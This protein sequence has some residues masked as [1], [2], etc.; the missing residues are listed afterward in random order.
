MG[1]E[2]SSRVSREAVGILISD[3]NINLTVA[4]KDLI[5]HLI[6]FVVSLNF[7]FSLLGM[8]S[9]VSYMLGKYLVLYFSHLVSVRPR[10]IHFRGFCF[11]MYMGASCV[12]SAHFG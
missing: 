12:C 10:E 5:L 9:R 11:S 1:K 6:H 3:L 7:I 4:S 8:E 2:D